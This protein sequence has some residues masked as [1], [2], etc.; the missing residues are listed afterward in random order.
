[1][2]SGKWPLAVAAFRTL[3]GLASDKAGA[4]YD[5]ARALVASGKKAEAKKEV[6][7]ALESAP[8]YREAQELLLK[9]SAE[10]D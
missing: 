10:A 7:R 1:M 4:H 9:L 6:L 8:S 2:Q 5:L 3:A